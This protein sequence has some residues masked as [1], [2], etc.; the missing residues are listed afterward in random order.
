VHPPRLNL[1]VYFTGLA[2]RLQLGVFDCLAGHQLDRVFNFLRRSGDPVAVSN[3]EQIA[4]RWC[5]TRD[6][7][8]KE[9]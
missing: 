9:N 8:P 4:A 2:I 7:R 5:A 3:I 6:L 1:A